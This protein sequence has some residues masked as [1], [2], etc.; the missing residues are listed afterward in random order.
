MEI[1]LTRNTQ[2]PSTP[3]APKGDVSTKNGT[4]TGQPA[5]ILAQFIFNILEENS[6]EEINTL[7]LR[8]KSSIADYMIVASGRSNRHVSALADYVQRGLREE[9]YPKLGVEGKE[10]CDWILIDA[11]DVILHLFRPEVREYYALEKMWSTPDEMSAHET[12]K[13]A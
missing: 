7:D 3:E 1:T 10:Q 4:S 11:G 9:Q 8:G 2:V 6:A 12:H 5:E 13:D